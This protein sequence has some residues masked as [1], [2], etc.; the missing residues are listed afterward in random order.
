MRIIFKSK[1]PQC[2]TPNCY[3]TGFNL[4][5]VNI[6]CQ[7]YSDV[8]HRLIQE[9]IIKVE[10]YESELSGSYK[11][12]KEFVDEDEEIEYNGYPGWFQPI[13]G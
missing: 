4:E 9:E 3:N 6:R 7:F 11:P 8:Q 2:N 1:C 12:K 5:C 13:K 10:K